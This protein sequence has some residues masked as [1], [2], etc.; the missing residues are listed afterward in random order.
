MWGT[1]YIGNT[2]VLLTL[3]YIY[4][5]V[6]TILKQRKLRCVIQSYD[7]SNTVKYFIVKYNNLL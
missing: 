1:R 7:Q 5:Y 6:V 4:V 2:S 3:L